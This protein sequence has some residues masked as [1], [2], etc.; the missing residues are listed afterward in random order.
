M[1]TVALSLPLLVSIAIVLLFTQSDA[2]AASPSVNTGS[3]RDN[4]TNIPNGTDSV[5]INCNAGEQVFIGVSYFGSATHITIPPTSPSGVGAFTFV[6]GADW[7][8][9]CG[10]TEWWTATA[11]SAQ[12]G[13]AASVVAHPPDETYLRSFAVANYG[14]I[15]NTA[16]ATSGTTSGASIHT[17]AITLS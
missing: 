2:Q 8:N 6:M 15:G 16:S 4:T 14:G 3:F 5:L 12:S 1:K 11:S 7:V 17:W 13:S 10:R 9:N